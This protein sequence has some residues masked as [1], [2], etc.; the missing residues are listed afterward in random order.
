MSK[1][2][3]TLCYFLICI[4]SFAQISKDR[5][6]FSVKDQSMW[7]S[8][9]DPITVPETIPLFNFPE[10]HPLIAPFNISEHIN[11]A[12][13]VPILGKTGVTVDFAT[14]LGL[15][16]EIS[17][18][19]WDGGSFD[20]EYPILIEYNFPAEKSFRPGEE[21]KITTSY[22]ILNTTD[23]KFVFEPTYPSLGEVKL[24]LNTLFDVEFTVSLWAFNKP[25]PIRLGDMLNTSPTYETTTL[26]GFDLREREPFIVEYP[27]LETLEPEGALKFFLDL[28][29]IKEKSYPKVV[30]IKE[31]KFNNL[32]PYEKTSKDGN[33][34]IGLDIPWVSD[35][36]EVDVD[37]KLFGGGPSDRG[38]KANLIKS[39]FIFSNVDMIG[40][41]G[42]PLN[43]GGIFPMLQLKIP[44]P[45]GDGGFWKGVGFNWKIADSK[46]NFD[47]NNR[48]NL[49]FHPTIKST[50]IFPTKVNFTI[51][52]QNGGDEVPGFS[53]SITFIVGDSIKVTYPCD[54]EFMEIRNTISMTDNKV[55]NRTWDTFKSTLTLDLLTFSITIEPYCFLPAIPIPYPFGIEWIGPF[56]IDIPDPPPF[57]PLVS[58][59][60]TLIPETDLP[61][62][63][64]NKSFKIEG[65]DESIEVNGN[66]RG[67]HEGKSF[68]LVPNPISVNLFPTTVEC[69]GDSTGEILAN[70]TAIVNDKDKDKERFTYRWSDGAHREPTKNDLEDVLEKVPAGTYYVKVTD[71]F[72]CMAMGDATIEESTEMKSE[73]LISPLLCSYSKDAKIDLKTEGGQG[74]YTYEW[75]NNLAAQPSVT[76]LSADTYRV[77]IK[78][79]HNCSIEDEFEII[80][81]IALSTA[82]IQTKNPLCN[83]SS[84]GSILIE[85]YGGTPP[86]SYV[87]DSGAKLPKARGLSQGTYGVLI[88]DKNG[89]ITD[90]STLL[91]DPELLETNLELLGDVSCKDG[92]DG[93]LKL[94]ITGGTQPYDIQ[95]FKE[96]NQLS[97]ISN[98][99]SNQRTGQYQA[100]VT[101]KN[102]CIDQK[103]IVIPEPE[104]H[105]SIA[106]S[107]TDISCFDGSDG[108]IQSAVTGGTAGYSYKWSNGSTD[109]NPSGL[110]AGTHQVTVT[111]DRDCEVSRSIVLFQEDPIEIE[112]ETESVSCE[113]KTDGK[114]IAEINGGVAPYTYNWENGTTTS[115][116]TD[117][118]EGKIELTITDMNLCQQTEVAYIDK[119]DQPCFN[120]PSGFSPN[121]DGINDT[122]V[123]RSAELYPDMEV[124][125]FNKWHNQIY[126]SKGY[127]EPWAG[128]ANNKNLPAGTYYYIVDLKNGVGEFRGPL[129]IIRAY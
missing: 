4:A 53:D 22:T 91:K 115:F 79:D 98:D 93:S 122:W 64:F 27:V 112:F 124:T 119:L 20:L 13:N 77:T 32:P 14:A 39:P 60:I 117:L 106:L 55:T 21:I 48:Q 129:T 73:A 92:N 109:Q 24:N 3:I 81:P 65:L 126:Y 46:L 35:D 50:L 68:K 95:W 82:F 17:L 90:A 11:A 38:L 127:P 51:F 59:T 63:Y 6:V 47:I 18:K 71:Q 88:T 58:E 12:P 121:N 100:V 75:T 118:D 108:T 99:I 40:L 9:T 78:D 57:P 120:I 28:N 104:D 84:D 69:Y 49:E 94:T 33:I 102:G 15:N 8:G 101:D 56:C 37:E 2:V 30:E 43:E 54:Y 97:Y 44:E 86:Y 7:T 16:S 5:A 96:E 10:T 1:I 80:A 89:C 34:T 85:T 116:V 110:M 52:P 26:A 36:K 23:D 41:L 123:I 61:I 42:L 103:S 74:P 76:G 83:G 114:A 25:L 31:M 29:G 87:W 72:G 113:D 125:I 107:K 66:A 62:D 105:L 70:V 128:T 111:D 67:N 19:G 45:G